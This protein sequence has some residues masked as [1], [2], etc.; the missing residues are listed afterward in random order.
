MDAKLNRVAKS[1]TRFFEDE[2]SSSSL[3]LHEVARDHLDR[4]RSFL[5]GYYIEQHGFWPPDK[6]D[7]EVVQRLVCTSMYS[8]FRSLYHHL[9]DEASTT[10]MT[11]D[12]ESTGGVC[13]LQNIQAF[14]SRYQLEPLPQSLPLLPSTTKMESTMH[15]KSQ[16]RNSWNPVLKRKQ[17]KE[18]R[19]AQRT[20][21]LIDSSNRDWRLMS[22]LL[23]RRYSDFEAEFATDGLES[24]S[25]ADGRKVRWIVVYG[26]L[27]TLA[28]IMQAPKQARNTDGLSYALCCSTPARFPWQAVSVVALPVDGK[29]AIEPDVAYSHTNV[30]PTTAVNRSLSKATSVKAT[31]TKVTSTKERRKSIGPLMTPSLSRNSSALRAPSLTRLMP[32]RSTTSVPDV[33]KRPAAFCEIYIPGYGNGL[34]AAEVTSS[35]VDITNYNIFTKGDITKDDELLTLSGSNSVS[36]ESSNASTNSTWSKGSTISSENLSTPGDS[37]I[38]PTNKAFTRL[39]VEARKTSSPDTIKASTVRIAAES[40]G[41]DTVFFNTQTWDEMLSRS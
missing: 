13:T 40:E 20:Q 11:T 30:V 22:C 41:L 10:D 15:S 38:T 26:I 3:G 29:R 33:P 1:I 16:R 18:L 39:D 32:K 9:A 8:D 36:R 6:F 2:L 17:D 14:D 28:S 24:I 25:L 4:F 37:P 5:H 35:P 31:S 7:E 21:A 19:H 12:L 34:N 23:V 27:Q